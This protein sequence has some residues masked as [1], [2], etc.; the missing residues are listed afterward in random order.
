M[1][2]YVPNNIQTIHQNATPNH[3]MKHR[4]N[5]NIMYFI[6]IFFCLA[7]SKV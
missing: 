5:I 2:P 4:T 1:M 6:S 7:K 3:R